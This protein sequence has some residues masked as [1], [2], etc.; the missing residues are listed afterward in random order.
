MTEHIYRDLDTKHKARI[1]SLTSKEDSPV[2]NGVSPGL[3]VIKTKTVSKNEVLSNQLFSSSILRNES[4]EEVF[5]SS[6]G[7]VDPPNKSK[8]SY[9]LTWTFCGVSQYP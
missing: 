3:R 2:K 7:S 5:Y 4:S 6:Q 9:R 1:C 8:L